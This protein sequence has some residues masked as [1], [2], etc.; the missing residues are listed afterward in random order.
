MAQAR[1]VVDCTDNM[2]RF[3]L[4]ASRDKSSGENLRANV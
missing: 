3:C 4:V 1:S 2:A